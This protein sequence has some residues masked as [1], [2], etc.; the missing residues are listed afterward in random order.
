MLL[1]LSWLQQYTDV[2][3]SPV[4]F[5]NGITDSGSHVDSIGTLGKPVSGIVTGHIEKIEAHPNAD[6]LKLVTV[7]LGSTKKTLV[8]AAPN[9]KEGWNV[10]VALDGAV[11]ANGTRITPTDFR[12]VISDGMLCSLEELGLP[13]SVIPKAFADG[14]FLT[15]EGT[16]G[17]PFQEVIGSDEAV[18]EIEVT[19]NRPDCLSVIGMARESAATFQTELRLP[20]GKEEESFGAISDYL[21]DIRL[22]SDECI[23]YM[24]R[25]IH[26]VV[27]EPSPQWMQN[28]LMQAGMRPINNIVDI[29]NYVMLEMGVPLHA[30]DID[31]VKDK[32]I[33]VR[34]AE[35]GE[36]LLLLNGTE[37]VLT[38]K[39][40]IIADSKDP[41]GMAGV[42]GGFD[43]EITDKTKNILIE[44][45]VFASDT[46][47]TSAK[48]HGLRS[49]A[50]SRYEK[51]LVPGMIPRVMDRV[52]QLAERIGVGKVVEGA[53][54]R[55]NDKSEAITI[56]IRPDR[57]NGHLG[58]NLRTDEMQSYLER[59][60]LQT[61]EDGDKL[62]VHVPEYR[63]DLRIP[64]DIAEEIARL[65][66]LANIQPKPVEGVL[67]EGGK[68]PIRRIEDHAREKLYGL[69][70]SEALTYS[71]I[72]EK[73]YDRL[74]IPADDPL[75]KVLKLKNP[76]GEDY[77]VM[78][79]TL[80]PNMLDIL[81]FNVKNG[82]D[83]LFIYE[84]G[85]TFFPTGE[86]LPE[87]RR[88]LALGMYGDAVDFYAMKSAIFT[89]LHA[90]GIRDLRVEECTDKPWF[91]PGRAAVLFAEGVE[92][93]CFGEISYAVSEGL[94]LAPRLYL[95]EFAFEKIAAMY[96]AERSYTAINRYPSMKRD[97][98]L[99]VDKNQRVGDVLAALY[100]VNEPIIQSIALFDIYEGQ[101]LPEGK[102]SLAFQV[103][104]QDPQ[105]TLKEEDATRV[106]KALIQKAEQTLG[107]TLRA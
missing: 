21:T 59:L 98:A 51:G 93:G 39:D 30:F 26:D 58:T 95:G 57:I 9:V 44:C 12:G 49:E 85:N 62:L 35:E 101:Q 73:A 80:L 65:Y 17:A 104:Y 47:R 106:H 87:E 72:S 84:L 15:K 76:L 45:A 5:A 96:R 2:T 55:N 79:T 19:P 4:A 81:A 16:P 32:T 6:R 60:F 24:G 86:E 97:L 105:Q 25:V 91:H 50:S 67:S 20:E 41:I 100:S 103:T 61:E 102:K 63:S 14:I 64:A 40:L 28:R 92:I 90:F 82:R 29:T 56:A 38:D 99:V 36:T 52:C 54:D 3:V 13:D 11:L 18:L 22:E 7:D 107:A 23:R 53:I 71:F 46:I 34:R 48:R 8:T 74:C 75:R 89:L 68:L 10:P 37:K 83:E 66:G 33:V 78:R 1:P 31:T 77:S 88:S 94:D 27:I 42:M 70:F 43:S 69:G